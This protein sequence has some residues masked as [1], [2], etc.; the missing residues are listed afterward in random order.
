MFFHA[1]KAREF[2]SI[3]LNWQYLDYRCGLQITSRKLSTNNMSINNINPKR[4]SGDLCSAH[5][6]SCSSTLNKS[7]CKRVHDQ[8][9]DSSI[10]KHWLVLHTK[11]SC[12][13]ENL[14][15]LFFSGEKLNFLKQN[16]MCLWSRHYHKLNE[17][18]IIHT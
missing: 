15:H 18:N 6:L 3:S 12:T 16:P 8:T 14:H 4:S 2:V 9:K 1:C 13:E 17:V 5:Q 10:L 7:S 11:G